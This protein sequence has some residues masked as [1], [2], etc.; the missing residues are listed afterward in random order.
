MRRKKIKNTFLTLPKGKRYERDEEEAYMVK[1]LDE[2]LAD[3]NP[4]Y[5]TE[6]EFWKLVEEREI[7]KYGE[8]IS[9]KIRAKYV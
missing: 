7:E 6:E 4:I 1:M 5:Y 2:A 9:S 3:S 8:A